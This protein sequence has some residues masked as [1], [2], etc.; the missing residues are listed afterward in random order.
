MCVCARVCVCNLCVLEQESQNIYEEHLGANGVV[1]AMT[2]M[3]EAFGA[4]QQ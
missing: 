3:V 1:S 4:R 2:A